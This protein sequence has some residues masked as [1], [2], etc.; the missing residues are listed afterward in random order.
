MGRVAGNGATVEFSTVADEYCWKLN[1]AP[2]ANAFRIIVI[3]LRRALD[4]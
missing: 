4:L 3:D 1:S 2:F